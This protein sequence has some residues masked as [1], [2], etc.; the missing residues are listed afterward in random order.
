M[1]MQE[2]ASTDWCVALQTCGGQRE[3]QWRD[4]DE[5]FL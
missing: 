1:T 5:H 2:G 3:F 4:T